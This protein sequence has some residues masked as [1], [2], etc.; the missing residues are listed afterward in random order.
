MEKNWSASFEHGDYEND[1]ELVINEAIEAVQRTAKGF[2]VN[3]VT[4]STFGN[5]Y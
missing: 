3:I 2:Y 1:V 4:P 5:S